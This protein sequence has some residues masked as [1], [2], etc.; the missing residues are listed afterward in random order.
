[1]Q[2]LT[3]SGGAGRRPGVRVGLW[4]TVLDG[5]WRLLRVDPALWLAVLLLLACAAYALLNGQQRAA[6]RAA[7]VSAAV[8]DEARRLA[9]LRTE[10]ER[11]ERGEAQVPPQA[12]RDP[13]NPVGVGRNRGAAVLHLADAPLASTAIGVSDLY[14][15]SFRVG[16]GSR[17]R[18]LFVDEIANP[19]QLATGGFD[20]AFVVVYLLPLVLIGLGHNLLSGEREGGTWALTLSCARSP[21]QVLAA[22]LMLRAGVPL[23]ALLATSL[24][25]LALTGA[26]GTVAG[27]AS[28]AA[29]CVTVLTYAA[30][31]LALVLWVNTWERDSAFNATFLAMAWVLALLVMPAGLNAV[32]QA[33]H[34]APDRA[35]MVLAVREAAVDTER[36]REAERARYQAEHGAASAGADRAERERQ[37]LR[38]TLE[39]DRRADAVLARHEALVR[40]Q[41]GLSDRLSWLAP[42]VRVH[43]ALAEIAGNGPSRWDA[44]L[45]Q[46]D[47][48]HERFQGFF[49]GLAA[50]GVR[51]GSQGLAL[52]PAGAAVV[53]PSTVNAGLSRLWETWIGLLA[54]TVLGGWLA[55]RR[56]ARVP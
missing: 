24:L 23:M 6:E 53:L 1:M 3:S 38:L 44:Y 48:F 15:P 28:A 43:E 50:N 4:R 16:V 17:D 10:L 41:R 26:L 14:P 56:L 9:G 18:F 19:L 5:E 34:P 29:W 22:R 31:W 35:E 27:L 8:Q 12:W 39:A 13:T 7:V 54:W 47:A 45:A 30:A 55:A 21:L 11:I 46:I 20:L 37:A 25:V 52:R 40:D 51:L 32:A 42:P 33:L 36:D 2:A 49:V